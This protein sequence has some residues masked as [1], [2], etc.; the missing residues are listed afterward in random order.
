M[1]RYLLKD[2]VVSSEEE[3]NAKVN[4]LIR[5]LEAAIEFMKW[6]GLSFMAIHGCIEW[7]NILSLHSVKP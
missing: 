3:L 5:F 6:V 4:S 2:L 7:S 1:C